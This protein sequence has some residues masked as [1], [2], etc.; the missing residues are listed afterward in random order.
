[1]IDTHYV[2]KKLHR[3]EIFNPFFF[4][5]EWMNECFYFNNYTKKH[6]TMLFRIVINIAE[7]SIWNCNPQVFQLILGPLLYELSFRKQSILKPF[8]KNQE[9][10]YGF[11]LMKS[12][13]GCLSS[14]H[15]SMQNPKFFPWL[16]YIV[17]LWGFLHPLHCYRRSFLCLS[18]PSFFVVT[19]H[20]SLV[21]FC[22]CCTHSHSFHLLFFFSSLSSFQFISL[23]W[24]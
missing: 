12:E 6:Y 23:F 19:F 7:F 10:L 17:F 9:K 2:L 15:F 18:F 13:Q 22:C 20:E 11:N 14:I 8:L 1:M 3:F 16:C 21:L 24:H 4:N 5:F